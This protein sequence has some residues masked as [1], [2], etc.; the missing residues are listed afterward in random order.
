MFTP[1]CVC[2][3]YIEMLAFKMLYKMIYYYLI[4]VPCWLLGI[5][6]F[7]LCFFTIDWILSMLTFFFF[8]LKRFNKSAKSYT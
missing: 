5:I 4:A 3:K 8:I 7:F 2:V 1:D 6:R